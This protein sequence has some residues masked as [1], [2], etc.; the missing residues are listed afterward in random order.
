MKIL[1]YF[2]FNGSS[3]KPNQKKNEKKTEWKKNVIQKYIIIKMGLKKTR[4]KKITNVHIWHC[5]WSDKTNG[6]FWFNTEPT[7]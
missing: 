3:S 5:H 2:T 4:E 6:S 7:R 1:L